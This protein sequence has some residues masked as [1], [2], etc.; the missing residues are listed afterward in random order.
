MKKNKLL[1]YSLQ[2]AMLNR[3]YV[4]NLID[5]MEYEKILKAL[6]KDYGIVSNITA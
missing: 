5:D 3:L 6:M 2:L 4:R 1:R